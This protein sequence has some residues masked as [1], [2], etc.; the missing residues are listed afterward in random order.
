VPPSTHSPTYCNGIDQNI[1]R[2]HLG[3]HVPT[4]APRNNRGGWVFSMWSV[5]R[6]CKR[7]GGDKKGSL[8]SGTVKYGRE[9]YGIRIWEWMRWRG[10]AAIVNDGHNLSSERMLYKSYDRRCSF[11]KQNL[12]VSLK[13]SR[14][15][16][17]TLTL[18]LTHRRSVFGWG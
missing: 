15:T 4:H 13:G 1:T 18:T 14:G 11:E 8:K 17:V 10:P 3:K 12:A 7:M 16:E 9:S 5:P 6:G 2:P